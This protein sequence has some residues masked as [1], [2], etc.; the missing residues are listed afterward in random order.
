MARPL[1]RPTVAVAAARPRF[2]KLFIVV[3][4]LFALAAALAVFTLARSAAPRHAGIERTPA[5]VASVDRP[6]MAWNLIAPSPTFAVQQATNKLAPTK[7]ATSSEP[8][9]SALSLGVTDAQAAIATPQAGGDAASP[10]ELTVAMSREERGRLMDAAR[11]AESGPAPAGY[12]PMIGA[13]VPPGGGD[14]ICR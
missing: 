7:A 5:T 6:S 3:I 8:D 10:L 1:D 2:G 9:W 14:G 13:L 12:C 11:E 4:T